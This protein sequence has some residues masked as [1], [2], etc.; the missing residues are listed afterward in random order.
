[1]AADDF[2]ECLLSVG[3]AL[4]SSLLS[5]SS[6]SLSS[7]LLSDCFGARSRLPGCQSSLISCSSLSL[8]DSSS[9]HCLRRS[10]SPLDFS[11]PK[12]KS[13]NQVPPQTARTQGCSSRQLDFKQE[14]ASGQRRARGAAGAADEDEAAAAFVRGAVA[15]LLSPTSFGLR[16]CLRL[17]ATSS[18]ILSDLAR[19]LVELR[20][21]EEAAEANAGESVFALAV[22]EL[23]ELIWAADWSGAASA[24]LLCDGAASTDVV[25][26]LE[27]EAA[28]TELELAEL[29]LNGFF[30]PTRRLAIR[31]V[32]HVL[33][34][35]C[36]CFLTPNAVSGCQRIARRHCVQGCSIWQVPLSQSS[37]SAHRSLIGCTRFTAS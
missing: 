22:A 5:D 31:C 10:H 15:S 35:F 28:G 26:E 19:I 1:M 30:V 34:R 36:V 37:L 7:S 4:P 17:R 16:L 18:S 23:L 11:K 12:C 33:N 29:V 13:G 25:A 24:E 2:R 32:R 27:A 8:E 14:S 20:G 21:A 9:G 6:C 3:A